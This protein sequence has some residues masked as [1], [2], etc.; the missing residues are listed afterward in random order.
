M[1]NDIQS[2]QS[3]LTEMLHQLG[4]TDM[5]VVRYTVLIF[6]NSECEYCQ[7]EMQEISK[8][9]NQFS[10][11][12]L[13]LAS[14]EPENQVIAFLNQHSL[15]EFYIKSNSEKV[16]SAFTDGVPQTLIYR[17]EKLIRHFK[18]EVKIEAIL[19]NLKVK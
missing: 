9:V 4:Q 5:E 16:M 7:W 1:K 17:K 18:G 12:Q 15:A 6:F 3:D 2:K 10:Q 19:E 13:L 8:N 14:F 11:H